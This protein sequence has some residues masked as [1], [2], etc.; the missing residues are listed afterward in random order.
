MLIGAIRPTETVELQAKGDSLEAIAA[1]LQVQI[2]DGWELVQQK[3]SM[4]KGSTML[5]AVGRVSRWGEIREV[6]GDDMAGVRSRVPDGWQLLS[7]RSV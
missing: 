2:P 7:V 1:A 3:V 4:I 5:T 6:E